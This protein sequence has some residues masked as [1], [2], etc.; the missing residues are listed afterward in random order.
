[1]KLRKA[2]RLAILV[3]ASAALVASLVSDKKNQK[4]EEAVSDIKEEE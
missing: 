1:M 3:A 2:G 4:E